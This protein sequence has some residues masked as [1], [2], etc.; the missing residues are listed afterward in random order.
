[1]TRPAPNLGLFKPVSSTLFRS[2][3]VVKNLL[4]FA[5]NSDLE[6]HIPHSRSY[7]ASGFTRLAT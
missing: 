2:V 1:V 7:S 4:G 3:K 6:I 5:C